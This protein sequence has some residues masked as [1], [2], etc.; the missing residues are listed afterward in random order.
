VKDFIEALQIFLKYGDPYNPTNCSHDK[1]AVCGGYHADNMTDED[2]LR[3]Q[4]LGFHWNDSEEY[5]YS[6]RYGSC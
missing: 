4:E 2:I 6:Y 3:L 1:L 5:F